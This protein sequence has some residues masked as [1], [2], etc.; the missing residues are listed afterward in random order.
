MKSDKKWNGDK[1]KKEKKSRKI[2]NKN[3]EDLS[4]Q[5]SICKES[6]FK[7]CG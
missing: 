6:E 5:S 2:E 4:Y 3:Y 7:P 1:E